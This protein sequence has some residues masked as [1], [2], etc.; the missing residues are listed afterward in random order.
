M[1]AGSFKKIVLS[2]VSCDEENISNTRVDLREALFTALVK[3]QDLRWLAGYED[4]VLNITNDAPVIVN[5]KH[6]AQL[7]TLR[8]MLGFALFESCLEK[9]DRVHYGLD[10]RRAKRT[11]VP[12]RASDVPSERSE[13]SHP[14]TCLLYTTLAYYFEGLTDAQVKEAIEYMLGLGSVAKNISMTELLVV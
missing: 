10:A 5:E 1:P 14:D 13:F 9:R 8:G 4:D 12:F 3:Q 11:A 2:P 6:Q 7:L